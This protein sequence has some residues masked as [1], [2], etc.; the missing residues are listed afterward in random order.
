MWMSRDRQDGGPH[1]RMQ[2]YMNVGWHGT[3]DYFNVAIVE[4]EPMGQAGL[5]FCSLKCMRHWFSRAMDDLER[6][7]RTSTRRRGRKR[8]RVSRAASPR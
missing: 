8:P 6:R 3:E 7:I 2:G 4:D 5:N 1:E